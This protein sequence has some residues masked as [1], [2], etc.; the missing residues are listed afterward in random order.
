LAAA[1]PLTVSKVNNDLHYQ[2]ALDTSKAVT[3]DHVLHNAQCLF[4]T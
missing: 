2:N 4:S 3:V 1:Y